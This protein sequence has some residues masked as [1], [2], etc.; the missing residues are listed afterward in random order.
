MENIKK[1]LKKDAK[2]GDFNIEVD[3]IPLIL[4]NMIFDDKPMFECEQGSVVVYNSCGKFVYSN[5][6]ITLAGY[7][8][9]I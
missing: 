6:V 3:G 2:R 8:S 1:T 9:A 4:Q 5:C 7:V